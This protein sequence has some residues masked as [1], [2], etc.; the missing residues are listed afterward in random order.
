MTIVG[1]IQMY[2]FLA[3]SLVV[4]AMAGLSLLDALLRPGAA[5]T[6]AGKR[7]KGFWVG[8]LA[9][10][11]LLAVLAVPPPIGAGGLILFGLLAAIPAGIYLADVRPA[12]RNY[13]DNRGGGGS[14]W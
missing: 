3:L 1:T 13:R 8:V 6:Y 7:T 12:V 14:P 4:V 11:F 2:L 9:L 5:F 10:A